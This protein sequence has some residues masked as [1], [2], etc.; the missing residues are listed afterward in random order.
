MNVP[1]YELVKLGESKGVLEWED[2]MGMYVLNEMYYDDD[3]PHPKD[4]CKSTG[5]SLR[6]SLS[7]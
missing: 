2:K 6:H 4:K 3:I 5:Y 7:V 1:P